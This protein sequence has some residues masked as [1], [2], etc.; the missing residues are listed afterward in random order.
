MFRKIVFPTNSTEFS[1]EKMYEKLAPGHTALKQ[2]RSTDETATQDRRFEYRR[3][4][5]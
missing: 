4:N 2:H 1:A 3:F 5:G